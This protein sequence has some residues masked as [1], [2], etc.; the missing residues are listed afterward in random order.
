MTKITQK[1]IKPKTD[2]RDMLR[3]YLISRSLKCMEISDTRRQKVLDGGDIDGYIKK[4]RTA[5]AGFY[6]KIPIGK[7]FPVEAITRVSVYEKEGYRIENVLF[8]SFPR[9]QVNATV[10]VPL[11]YLPPFLAVIV[12]VGHSG[13][14]FE[15]Y[16]LPCQF[17]ARAGYL[18]IVFDPPGQS[19]E[20]IPG[21]DHF[22]DGVRCY[23]I[24]ET[25]SQYFIADALRC[26]DYLETRDDIDMTNGVAL[27]GVSGGGTTT[28][29]AT[30]LDERITVAGPSCCVTRLSDLDI[31]QCYSGCPETHMWQRYSLGI[32]E[33]DLICA[34]F[35][36]PVLLMAG[37]KDETFRIADTK[38]LTKIVQDFYKLAGATEK[39]KFF[40]DNKGHC[41][42]I[43]QAR[44]FTKFMNQF[45]RQKPDF[46]IPDLPDS[47][48]FLDPYKEIRCYP[49]TDVN[50]RTR[51]V[52][53]ADILEKERNKD[54]R[55]VRK[56]AEIMA[57][58]SDKIK[59]PDVET[60]DSF[61][62]WTHNW[63]QLMIRPE[64]GIELPATYL[65]S[66]DNIPV[67]TLLH[68][69]DKDRHN[70]LYDPGKLS[71]VIQFG[72]IDMKAFGLFTVDLRGWGDTK[73]ALYPYE[74]SWWGSLDRFASYM[75]T[76]LGD[77]IMSMRI[78]DGLASL[79]Y[80]RSRK[81]CLTD[82]IVISGCGLGGI[83]ALHVAAIDGSVPGTVIWDSPISFRNL[84]ETE[85][86]VWT[87]DV[88]IPN[89]LKYY[90]ILEL[91]SSIP[92]KICIFNPLD[93][94]AKELPDHTLKRFQEKMGDGVVI[95][96]QQWSERITEI[97]RILEELVVKV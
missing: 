16:Q 25:S 94:N 18:A 32:D 54:A 34:A 90:D 71:T 62:V 81:E 15:D 88:F 7:N 8:D 83:V 74:L 55:V 9:W 47:A 37:E 52:E 33:V 19:S 72:C 22:I 56:K 82:A 29:F 1:P 58:V 11:D 85:N 45:L 57:G 39:F 26:I 84:L 50:M 95:A 27:T 17:F 28:T 2:L 44:E 67:P 86:Y 21:N 24:G 10:Y 64:Q 89:V 5:V 97:K 76:A 96:N 40:I 78:R 36:K 6:G 38:E 59:L 46:Q 60:G 91:A 68:F 41:Y 75:S 92:G 66:A 49:R 31:S 43:D 53:K 69:D 73:M 51:A 87:Q 63:E 13:K 79:A 35:P 23:P 14:Q 30:L 80:L 20:K 93:G 4:I 70:L 12:P 65:Y 42:S 77:H 61:R 3:Q 48:F